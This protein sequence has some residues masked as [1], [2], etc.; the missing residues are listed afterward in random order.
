[1]AAAV[2]EVIQHSGDGDDAERWREV[3]QLREQHPGWVII[4]L[5]RTD[6]YRA[7]RVSDTRRV[8]ALTA[9][10]ATGLAAQISQ[11]RSARG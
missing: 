5:A 7:Y 10:T 9:I 1:V 6:Q 2:P 4:W 11:T 8:G 3:E